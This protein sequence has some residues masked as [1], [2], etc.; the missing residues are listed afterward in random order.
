MHSTVFIFGVELPCTGSP[1][2]LTMLRCNCCT[3]QVSFD[4]LAGSAYK[5]WSTAIFTCHFFK[6]VRWFRATL[7]TLINT[8]SYNFVSLDG[9][10]LSH[11]ALGVMHGKWFWKLARSNL[12]SPKTYRQF[13]QRSLT[14]TLELMGVRLIEI[15][16][17]SHSVVE[18]FD[19]IED[20][21]PALSSGA[22]NPLLDLFALQI[23]DE[24]FEH[25]V[26]PSVATAAHPR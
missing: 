14:L 12:P 21:W 23:T 2:L 3:Q 20:F 22:L 9:K 8:C 24:R 25:R 26:I 4:N 18:T 7:V 19:V 10:K 13:S 16:V 5:Y 15:L 17:A 1:G 6:L 11:G